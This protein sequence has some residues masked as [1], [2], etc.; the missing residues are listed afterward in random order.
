MDEALLSLGTLYPLDLV[1][2]AGACWGF[3]GWSRSRRLAWA[4]GIVAAIALFL[5]LELWWQGAPM[6]R[7]SCPSCAEGCLGG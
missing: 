7:P 6:T 2:V 4:C 5:A 1:A 3:A